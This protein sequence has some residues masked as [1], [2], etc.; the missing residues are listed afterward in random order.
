MILNKFIWYISQA[1]SRYIFC[2]TVKFA[3]FRKHL[4]TPLTAQDTH[5]LTANERYTGKC[6]IQSSGKD[7]N[8]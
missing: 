8:G 2:L 4:A 6:T 3:I 5:K 1:K 7:E